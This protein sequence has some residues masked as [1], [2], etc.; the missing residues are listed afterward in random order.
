MKVIKELEINRTYHAIDFFKLLMAF[1]VVAIHTNPIVSWT[2]DIATQVVVIIEEWAVPFFFVASGFFFQ[3]GMN[4]KTDSE[5]S[6]RTK[7]YL[8]KIIKLYCIWTILSIPVIIY[9][10]IISGNGL[11]SCMLSFVKY[12]LFVGKLYHAYHLWY[13]LALIYALVAIRFLHKKGAKLPQMFFVAVVFYGFNEILAWCGN[14]MDVLGGALGRLVQVYQFVF[15]KGGIFTGMVY[16]VIGMMIAAYRKYL[17]KRICI[18]GIIA[19][20]ILKLPMNA[21]MLQ[22]TKLIEATLLFMALLDISLPDSSLWAKCR[23]AS[24][25]IYL[26]HL[27]FYSLYTFIVIRKPDKM[28]IDS[29][30]VTSIMCTAYIVMKRIVCKVKCSNRNL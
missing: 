4:G 22:W 6:D 23:K 8:W 2:N 24:T 11:V 25:D 30:V 7:R 21:Y 9:G 3:N 18:V 13:L 12:F 29:F 17:D 16:V 14:N 19:L 5:I 1:A 10:Y 28:G 27:I 20:N 26:S 15:N